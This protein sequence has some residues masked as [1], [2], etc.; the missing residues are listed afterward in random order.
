MSFW[1]RV[2]DVPPSSVA[3]KEEIIENACE[4]YLECPV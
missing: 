1:K 4:E 2:H 3:T